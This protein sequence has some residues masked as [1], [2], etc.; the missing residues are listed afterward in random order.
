MKDSTYSEKEI[1]Y[2]I[3]LAAMTQEKYQWIIT[4]NAYIVSFFANS[5][6]I[7]NIDALQI[8]MPMMPT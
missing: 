8:S 6:N 4:N 5:D 1:S 2:V 7:I 3:M